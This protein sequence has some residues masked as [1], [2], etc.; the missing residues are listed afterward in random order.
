MRLLLTLL[1]GLLAPA[2]LCQSF[3]G[4][5]ALSAPTPRSGAR[6]VSADGSVVVG[7]SARTSG[8]EAFRWTAEDGMVG[9]GDFPGG[10]FFSEASGVSG[11]G[12]VVVGRG[13]DADD[14]ED[15]AFRWTAETGLVP[16]AISSAAGPAAAPSRPPPTGP[17]SSAAASAPTASKRSGGPTVAA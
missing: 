16:P 4:L 5:G 10:T 3:Q 2:A 8:N 6:G 15:D 7:Y 13:R 17:S 11:D 1:A 9:L 12:A 14:G